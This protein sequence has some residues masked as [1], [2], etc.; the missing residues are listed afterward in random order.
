MRVRSDFLRANVKMVRIHVAKCLHNLAAAGDGEK[1]AAPDQPV[2]PL[3][4]MVNDRTISKSLTS[5]I[6]SYH[7]A[8][9]EVANA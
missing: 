5:S 7:L 8:D 1:L 4:G 2:M 3:K 6:T 9:P